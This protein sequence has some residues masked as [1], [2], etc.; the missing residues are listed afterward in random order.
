MITRYAL[1]IH[2]YVCCTD[3][4]TKT[5]MMC[6]W[7]LMLFDD[8]N[9]ENTRR[10]AI[11]PEKKRRKN[12][13]RPTNT[14]THMWHQPR[15]LISPNEY[16]AKRVTSIWQICDKNF[17]P[18]C[19]FPWFL[20]FLHWLLFLFAVSVDISISISISIGFGF[21]IGISF[22]GFVCVTHS[23]EM[24]LLCDEKVD[25]SN[26]YVEIVCIT[27]IIGTFFTT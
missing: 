13:R 17:F 18:N 15:H 3:T 9:F 8:A 4:N 10:R 26:K 14:Q 19:K 5:H 16:L 1:R 23:Q 27:F 6:G 12:R 25:K 11:Y 21:G 24:K 2:K 7:M 22:V 20:H